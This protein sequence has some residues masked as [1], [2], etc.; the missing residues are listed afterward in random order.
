[1]VPPQPTRTTSPAT[2][3]ARSGMTRRRHPRL[4]NRSAPAPHAGSGESSSSR[5]VSCS[6][7]SASAIGSWRWIDAPHAGRL[8]RCA[9]R[10][11]PAHQ[12]TRDLAVGAEAPPGRRRSHQPPELQS[13]APARRGRGPLRAVLLRPRPLGVALRSHDAEP[14]NDGR[15][16]PV[17]RVCRIPCESFHVSGA[18][19][20]ASLGGSPR[21]PQLQNPDGM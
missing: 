21:K 6:R 3:T 14:L 11:E 4:R 20:T 17:V 2:E 18:Y 9:C 5:S 10:R 1:M 13:R 12:R 8:G 19:G 16:R 15:F 7:S